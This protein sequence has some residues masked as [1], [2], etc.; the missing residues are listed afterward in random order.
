[1]MESNLH[2][3]VVMN[4]LTPDLWKYM[5]LAKAEVDYGFPI[6]VPQPKG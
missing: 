4:K 2:F 3:K 6:D 1:M 5:D